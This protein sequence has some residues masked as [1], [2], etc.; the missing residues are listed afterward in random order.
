MPGK[1]IKPSKRT[2]IDTSKFT[3]NLEGATGLQD[4]LEI[5]DQLI[6]GGGGDIIEIV[7]VAH[8]F[9][10]T[11]IY[12]N[13]TKWVRALADALEHCATHFAVRVD[14]DN[15]QLYNGGE[16]SIAGIAAGEYFWLS[17]T[18][19]GEYT[20]TEPS[21]GVIQ[22]IMKSNQAGQATI[23]IEQ[24]SIPGSAIVDGGTWA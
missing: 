23:L 15:F 6:L 12:H 19:P 20:A 10:N 3:K 13:G 11:F 21:D 18:D 7:Q 5:T 22:T 17:Q 14:D 24:P 4:A 1:R 16:I 8:G 9:D 2:I